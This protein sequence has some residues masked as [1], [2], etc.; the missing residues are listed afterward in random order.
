M[1]EEQVEAFGEYVYHLNAGPSSSDGAITRLLAVGA[2]SRQP[3]GRSL[4]NLQMPVT[5][6][7]VQDDDI[8]LYE[9]FCSCDYWAIMLSWLSTDEPFD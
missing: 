6:M 8:Y 5:F 2:W 1:T 7:Y 9:Y 3:L 4:H